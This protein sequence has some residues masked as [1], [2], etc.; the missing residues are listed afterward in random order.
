VSIELWGDAS[1]LVDAEELPQ[2]TLWPAPP[3][4]SK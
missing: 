4:T 1:H 3:D 2:N